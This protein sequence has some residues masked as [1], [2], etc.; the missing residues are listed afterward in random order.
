MISKTQQAVTKYLN[1]DR[2]AA[3]QMASTFRLGLTRH[4]R[5]TLQRGYECLHSPDFYKQL[6]RNPEKCI[7]EAEELFKARFNSQCN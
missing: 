1:G 6:G 7:L 2:K 4:E 5:A 3:L